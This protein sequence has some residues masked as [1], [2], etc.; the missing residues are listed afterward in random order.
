[1]SKPTVIDCNKGVIHVTST[2]K[3]CY[4][5]D[6]KEFIELCDDFEVE[7]ILRD[8]LWLNLKKECVDLGDDDYDIEYDHDDVPDDDAKGYFQE[9]FEDCLREV[10]KEYEKCMDCC[11]VLGPDTDIT[12]VAK[13]SYEKTICTDCWMYDRTAMKA[14]GW[15]I[16]DADSDEDESVEGC[17]APYPETADHRPEVKI[18]LDKVCSEAV[19]D[20]TKDVYIAPVDYSEVLYLQLHMAKINAKVITEAAKAFDDLATITEGSNIFVR[21]SVVHRMEQ[22][23][24]TLCGICK[25]P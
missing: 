23:M 15:K 22:L 9:T 25:A 1:M 8:K 4:S 12:I 19:K 16:V 3:S 14:E 2:S 10:K 6:Y 11:K 20:E 21:K 7:E 18:D 24:S 13:E 5:Y 17:E